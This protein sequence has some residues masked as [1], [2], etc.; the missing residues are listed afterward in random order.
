M[1]LPDEKELKWFER[2]KKAPPSHEEHGVVDTWEH[3]LSESLLPS[4]PRNWR[5]SGNE[6]SCDT[7]FGPLTQRI[8]PNY[9]LLGEDKAHLPILKKLVL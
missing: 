8:P 2:I 3:P 1:Q 7:D 4:N 6:L 5:L 9:I